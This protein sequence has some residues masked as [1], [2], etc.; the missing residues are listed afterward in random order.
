MQRGT[1]TA[2][3]RRLAVVCLVAAFTE[4]M[5]AST[6]PRLTARRV[7][8][9]V[10]VSFDLQPEETDDLAHRLAG[11]QPV[12]VSW[13]MDVRRQVPFWRD[14]PIKRGVLKVTARRGP[15]P[16]L[17]EVDRSLNGRS[18]G[19]PLEATLEETYRHLTSFVDVQMVDAAPA[20][21]GAQYRLF[22][23]AILEGGGKRIET[24]WLAK[25]MVEP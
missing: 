23:K 2:I 1:R 17:F 14:L 8:S 12:W 9:S 13:Q 4:A 21:P 11:G 24:R 19:A 10:S 7:G 15:I 20:E 16:G 25:G 22:I 6:A 3:S 5:A 18:L